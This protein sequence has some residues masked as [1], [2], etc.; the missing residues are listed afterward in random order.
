MAYPRYVL[1]RN[2]K[3]RSLESGD[4]VLP[5]SEEDWMPV[6]GELDIKLRAQ[7][8][9]CIEFNVNG[10]YGHVSAEYM[11]LDVVT[12]VS[13]QD[14]SHVGNGGPDGFGI[15][16]WY[17]GGGIPTTD[18]PLNGTCI[19]ELQPHDIDTDN[20]VRLSL[21][22]RSTTEHTLFASPIAPFKVWA[23]NLGPADDEE[24]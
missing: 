22:Y 15:T 3:T 17:F 10:S 18:I 9:D 19:Y 1:A 21:R 23:K 2:F 16:G 4:L 11:A 6:S 24:E 7:M 13:G 8:G 20:I 14:R 12:I 5:A